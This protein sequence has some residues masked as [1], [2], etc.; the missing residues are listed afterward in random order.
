MVKLDSYELI[1]IPSP[2]HYDV[3]L[4]SQMFDTIDNDRIDSVLLNEVY[5]ERVD[6]LI[7]EDKKIHRKAEELSIQ[8]K[9]FTIDSFLEKT[10]AEHPELVNYKVLNVQK[11]KFG[12]INLKGT[13]I[14]SLF[15]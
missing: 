6:I 7:T 8:D 1:E 11:L 10:F 9:V 14:N 15:K 13:S 3:T 2:F 5:V 12:K 4:V